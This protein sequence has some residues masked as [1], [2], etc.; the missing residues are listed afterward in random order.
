MSNINKS[1]YVP[2]QNPFD[3]LGVASTATDAEITKAF[4]KKALQLHPDKQQGLTKNQ[5]DD[6]A[7]E[8]HQVQQARAFLLDAD[9]A[10]ARRKYQSK[11]ESQRARQQADAARE[12]QMSQ[13]RKRMRDELRKQEEDAK[14]RSQSAN[15]PTSTRG[16]TTTNKDHLDHLRRQGNQMRQDY[17]ERAAATATAFNESL[18]TE[19]SKNR[20]R[21]N[22]RIEYRQIRLKWSRKKLRASSSSPSEH[23]IASLLS[24][25]GSVEQVELIGSKGNAALV[26]F[27]SESSCQ[28]CVQ[29]YA[30]SEEMR[31]SYVGKRKEDEEEREAVQA[32]EESSQRAELT[33]AR[34]T[35]DVKEW[36]LR[37]ANERER[38]MRQMKEDDDDDDGPTASTRSPSPGRNDN[39]DFG[40]SFPPKFPISAEFM[41]MKLPLEKLVMAESKLLEGIIADEVIKQLK[42]I[43]HTI[44]ESDRPVKDL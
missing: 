9:Y 17:A 19:S 39:G 42:L 38:L 35:E 21:E 29:F 28:P 6:M 3:V 12:Q 2:D 16:T 25:F 34:D 36:K 10:Q 18:K 15:L 32:R 40:T 1:N 5:Q 31:A 37:Q 20:K 4:R 30:T 27:A 8:F 24:R 14:R 33:R 22:E 23:S 26:T 13:N 11:L 41:K 7:H 44:T 43:G